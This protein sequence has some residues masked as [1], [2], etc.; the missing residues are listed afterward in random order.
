VEV[1]HDRASFLACLLQLGF[2][3]GRQFG[4][5]ETGLTAR[6]IS[7]VDRGADSRGRLGNEWGQGRKR[8]VGTGSGPGEQCQAV[9]EKDEPKT[10]ESAPPAGLRCFKRAELYA[11]DG[12]QKPPE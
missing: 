5:I 8:V 9:G 11:G 6:L 1:E 2:N 10:F 3:A 7:W 12:D 4:C